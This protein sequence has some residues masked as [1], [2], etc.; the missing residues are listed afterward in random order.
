MLRTRSWIRGSVSLPV[1]STRGFT[2]ASCKAVK[3][4]P[5][6]TFLTARLI[7]TARQPIEG[8]LLSY[9][10]HDAISSDTRKM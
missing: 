5:A 8:E 4:Y 7:L 10:S 2:N 9:V 3:I 1:P 6:P